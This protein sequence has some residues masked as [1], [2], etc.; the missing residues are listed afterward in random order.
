M[1]AKKRFF[2]KF[3]HNKGLLT[4]HMSISGCVFTNVVTK[5]YERIPTNHLLIL[6]R[7][8]RAK[9]NFKRKFEDNFLQENEILLYKI[10]STFTTLLN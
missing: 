5:I 9:Y 1:F 6:Q 7:S 2:A 4:A 10:Q 3:R 8:K